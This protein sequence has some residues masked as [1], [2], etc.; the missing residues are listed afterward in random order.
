[1]SEIMNLVLTCDDNY[2]Q[3]AAITLMSAYG[4]TKNKQNLAT[5]ILDG[6]ISE[7]KK[8]KIIQ[9]IK[10]CGGQVSFI[11]I[12]ADEYEGMYTS[13]Q[14]SLAIY[15]RLALPQILD[16]SKKKCIYVDCDLLF[17]DDIE[18]LWNIDLK[19]HPI[20]AIEDIGLT[21][22][23]KRFLEKQRDIGLKATS[24]YFNSG[25]VIMDL[26]QWRDKGYSNIALELAANNDFK[27]HDQDVLNKLFMDN[28]EQID[29]R[30]NVIPPITYLYPK[31]VLNK[32][33]RERSLE[34]RRN[35]GILH[36][37]GRYK[38]WEF[39]EY[40]EFNVCYYK[41]LKQSA[42]KDEVMPQLSK[43][44]IGRNFNKELLK[45]RV[46]DWLTNIL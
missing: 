12:D 29:L 21:T 18:K 4:K 42:F 24:S 23:K 30:W 28:W 7:A 26:E 27:S 2:A 44:N 19:C 33:N 20:G 22:S 45:L 9:S 37:A 8:N 11:K 15:Y 14:Y 38:A 43:Q 5:F 35:P 16:N 31:I 34:A 6:G 1:M 46:A 13:H 17:Y 36:Y 39:A 25:V 41:L 40:P 3:H 10:Q 32:K